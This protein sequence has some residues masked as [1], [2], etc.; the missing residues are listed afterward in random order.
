MAILPKVEGDV[1]LMK[2]MPDKSMSRGKIIDRAY[3]FNVLN[4]LRKDYLTHIVTEAQKMRAKGV[5]EHG[6][7]EQIMMTPAWFKIL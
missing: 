4:T 2:Y 6:D 1:A 7:P 3:F 5:V